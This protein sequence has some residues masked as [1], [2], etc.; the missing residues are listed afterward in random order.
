LLIF[1]SFFVV[2]GVLMLFS[3]ACGANACV[4]LKNGQE[5]RQIAAMPMVEG[6]KNLGPKNGAILER[7]GGISAKKNRD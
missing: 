3:V 2:A 1:L 7:S 4:D 5:P 6:S